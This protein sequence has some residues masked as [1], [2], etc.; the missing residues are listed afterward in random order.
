MLAPLT[1]VMAVYGQ[2][3]MLERHLNVVRTYDD[4]VLEHL[5]VIVVDD[6]GFPPVTHKLAEQLGNLIDLE[7]YRITKDVPWNQMGARNLGMDRA[8]PGWCA[9]MDPD[10]VFAPGMIRRVMQRTAKLRR[11]HVMRYCLKSVGRKEINTTS[12]NTYIIHRED[13]F[14]AGGY[15]EDYAGHKGWSDVQL[16]DVLKAHYTMSQHKDMHAEFYSND[17]VP[18]ATVPSAGGVDRKTAHNR[19]VRL[20]KFAEAKKAG[21]WPKWVKSIKGPNLRQ[22]WVQVYPTP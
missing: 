21:G 8:R 11:R 2:P 20:R 5:R 4:E 9:M 22:P 18:D 17:I 12:P 3:R 7:V 14:A 6:C 15:D 16:L 13:F 19:K 1:I 10:M